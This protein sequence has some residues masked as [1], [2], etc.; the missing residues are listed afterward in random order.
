MEDVDRTADPVARVSYLDAVTG[1]E[2][3]QAYKRQTFALM[4]IRPG[5]TVLDVGCGTGDDLRKLAELV[6]PSGH[7]I[8]V[9]RSE[10]MLREARARTEGLSVEC[11]VGDAHQLEFPAN[12]FDACRSDRVFQHLE[13]P[14]QAIAELVRVTR[15]GGRVVVF[16]PDY[17]TLVVDAADKKLTR[18]IVAF[19]SDSHREGWMGRRLRALAAQSGLVDVTVVPP[20][21]FSPTGSKRR[22]SLG[23]RPQPTKPCPLGSSPPTKQ[24]PGFTTWRSEPWPMCFSAP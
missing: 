15:Q 10:A 4:A 21:L 2:A 12:M 9:D 22:T 13:Q 20:H 18:R 19:I 14:R 6:G 5:H 1:L 17:D 8:G 23:S 16:D 3:A 11:R 7:V 24:R